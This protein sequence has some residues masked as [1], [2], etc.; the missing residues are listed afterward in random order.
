MNI[1]DA[2]KLFGIENGNEKYFYAKVPR[3]VI[4]D[5]VVTDKGQ[6]LY[7]YLISRCCNED[8]I[9]WVTQATMADDL[10]MSRERVNIN[11]KALVKRGLIEVK[12]VSVLAGSSYAQRN[13]YRICD[14][15]A[16]YGQDVA[17]KPWSANSTETP[18]VTQTSHPPVTETSHTYVTQTSHKEAEGQE[19][20]IKEKNSLRPAVVPSNAV[21]VEVC[22]SHN[23]AF[24][25]V[26]EEWLEAAK[27]QSKLKIYPKNWT[28]DQ[29]TQD[30][31]R[32]AKFLKKSYDREF[33]AEDMRYI[34]DFIFQ[35][36][37]FVKTSYAPA[38]L[39]RKWSDGRQK[40]LWVVDAMKN[41]K[42]GKYARMA[43]NMA[44]EL[45]NY[46]PE[47]W[48]TEGLLRR[49]RGGN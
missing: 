10:G 42:A 43:Q 7:S 28:V 35:D 30:L 38:S 15:V 19:S 8:G 27:S 40:I 4:L 48:T 3:C 46:N 31:I 12:K 25:Q 26:A 44:E 16:V 5:K 41:S 45:E 36:E 49:A 17:K 11:L 34:K 39:L 22:D 1:E 47:D 29:Y 14:V 33:T 32:T 9:T 6:R 18:H 24:R 13:V 2:K 23:H 21:G 20:E 37:F